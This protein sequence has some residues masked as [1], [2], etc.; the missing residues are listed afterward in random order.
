MVRFCA[1]VLV[2]ACG[3]VAAQTKPAP[4]TPTT[5]AAAPPSVATRLG[6]SLIASQRN[7]HAPPQLQQFGQLAG[8]WSCHGEG[9]QKDGSFK[10]GPG[11]TWTFFYTLNGYAVADIFKPGVANRPAGINLRIYDSKHNVWRMVWWVHPQ[12]SYDQFQAT[13]ADGKIVMTGDRP[14]RSM[15]RAHRARIT[16]HSMTP[17]SFEWRYEAAAPGSTKFREVQRISCHRAAP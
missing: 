14:A 5:H 17:K 12:T 6:D 13:Y 1:L 9:L 10:K 8:T 3:G 7:P 2:A 15:F 4:P 11:S 16:F